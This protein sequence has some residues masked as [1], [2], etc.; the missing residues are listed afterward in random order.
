M[1]EQNHMMTQ[2]GHPGKLVRIGIVVLIGALLLGLVVSSVQQAA[3]SQGYA[4]GLIAGGGQGD[5]LSQYLL[6]N[7]GALGNSGPG[8]G[9]VLFIGLMI[10][11]FFALMRMGRMAMWRSRG[12]PGGPGGEPWGRWG[13]QGMERDTDRS[14]SGVETTEPEGAQPA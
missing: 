12:G 11:G 1:S 7:N 3:W 8:F 10:F 4:L 2:H 6:Y 14:M 5:T 9:G 13:C